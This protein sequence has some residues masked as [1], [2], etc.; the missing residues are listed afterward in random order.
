M[1][2]KAWQQEAAGRVVAGLS[3]QPAR[4]EHPFLSAPV[5]LFIQSGT[6]VLRMG[7]PVFKVLPP[8]PINPINLFSWLF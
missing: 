2:G 8:T 1:M 7:L 5:L 6:P 4:D 3:E